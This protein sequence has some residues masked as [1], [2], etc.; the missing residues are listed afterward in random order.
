[1]P[2]SDRDRRTLK[3]G[4]IIAGIL[5]LGVLAMNLLSG[6][7]DEV[8]IPPSARPDVTETPEVSPTTTGT[9]VPPAPIFTGRDPFSVPPV[10]LTSGGTTTTTTTGGTT[11]TSGGTTTTTS[12]GTTTSS[13]APTQPGNGSA[14]NV[15][16]HDVVLLDVF[17]S[18][19]VGAVQVE[20]NGQVYNVTVGETF[21]PGGN[22]EL[23]ST[24]GNCATF[25]YGDESF[26]LCVSP[27]K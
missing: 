22:F 5:V 14:T 16:G 3:W 23:R 11:T 24:S 2:L 25:R 15:G 27:E 21:G 8:V 7:D 13:T 12:G 20:V 18:N 1:M 10:F 26:T 4:G 17:T 9:T 6:G 19:G